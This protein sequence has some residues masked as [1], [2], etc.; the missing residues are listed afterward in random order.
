MA[1]LSWLTS[2]TPSDSS[3]RTSFFPAMYIHAQFY[4]LILIIIIS[5]LCPLVQ[6]KLGCPEELSW[7]HSCCW[8][9]IDFVPPIT[10]N[11]I[12]YKEPNKGDLSCQGE[13][14]RRCCK[15]DEVCLIFKNDIE[16]DIM[17]I[18]MKTS[19]WRRKTIVPISCGWLT[20]SCFRLHPT[21]KACAS[22]AIHPF[23]KMHPRYL[24][25]RPPRKIHPRPHRPP[26]NL[27]AKTTLTSSDYQSSGPSW[28][29]SS[30]GSKSPRSSNFH[31]NGAARTRR[32]KKEN[33]PCKM[34]SRW[35]EGRS[36][37]VLKNPRI[38]Y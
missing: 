15:V 8:Y 7:T 10:R 9:M 26:M 34:S 36:H 16:R 19:S 2:Q 22:C 4:F 29:K 25:K 3:Q 6:S 38:Q 32:L 31:P 11:L 37:D 5:Q 20:T 18:R 14:E 27:R 12:C 33:V 21:Q 13:E 30:R 17:K 24:S 1:D 35:A 28:T 23:R